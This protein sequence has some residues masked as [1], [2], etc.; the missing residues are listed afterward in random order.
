MPGQPKAEYYSFSKQNYNQKGS[1]DTSVIY[2][3]A[4]DLVRTYQSGKTEKVFTYIYLVFKTDG[5]ALFSNDSREPFNQV[6]IYT[7]GG[8]YCYYK[9]EGDELQLELYDHNVKKFTIMY[10]KLLPDRVQFYK[11]KLRTSGGGTSKLD[12]PFLKSSIKYTKPL[13]WPE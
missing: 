1:V 6:N 5:I 4:S 2:V 3:Y 8:Q 11:D 12:M 10:A 7:I 9:V 13:T